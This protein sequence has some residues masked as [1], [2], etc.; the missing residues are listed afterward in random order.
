MA[1]GILALALAC[2][3]STGVPSGV[4]GCGSAPPL[5][6]SPIAPANLSH[7]APLGQLNPSGHVFPTDHMYFNP[8]SNPAG[9]GTPVPVVSP[10]KVTVGTVLLQ[11]RLAPSAYNDYGL[12]IYPC[13]DVM[14]E[15]QHLTALDSAFAARLGPMDQSCDAPYSTG[16]ITV[17]QCRK[18]VNVTLQ[19]GE[20]LGTAGGPITFGLDVGAYD[21]RKAPLHWVTTAHSSGRTGD[22]GQAYTA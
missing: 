16:G 21:R 15:F 12:T 10:G 20:R 6:T 8:P 19:P 14:I 2:G 22:F 1:C 17:Q 4:P 11:K 18:S 5:A 3:D 7:I 13:S 9:G